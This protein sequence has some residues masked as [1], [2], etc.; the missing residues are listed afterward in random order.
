MAKDRADASAQY[1]IVPADKCQL[2]RQPD[3]SEKAHRARVAYCRLPPSLVARRQRR[4]NSRPV[5]PLA[6]A[7][8]DASD[9]RFVVRLWKATRQA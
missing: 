3:E 6:I 1:A 5:T 7:L 8:K 4:Q 9:D 2:Q